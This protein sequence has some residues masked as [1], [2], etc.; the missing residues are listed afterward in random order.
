MQ[1]LSASCFQIL[2]KPSVHHS[3]DPC[4]YRCAPFKISSLIALEE[5]VFTFSFCFLTPCP[6]RIL[7]FS[8]MQLFEN[9]CKSSWEQHLAANVQHFKWYGV[10]ARAGEA[11]R[12]VFLLLCAAKSAPLRQWGW[13]P[14]VQQSKLNL[15]M[16]LC[17]KYLSPA[18]YYLSPDGV[19]AL[20]LQKSNQ[21][22]LMGCER[23]SLFLPQHMGTQSTYKKFTERQKELLDNSFFH[24]GLGKALPQSKLM[25]CFCHQEIFPVEQKQHYCPPHLPLQPAKHI[26]P[27][28]SL[29]EAGCSSPDSV[30]NVTQGR[31]FH[32]PTT[33]SANLSHLYPRDGL[34]LDKPCLIRRAASSK[35]RRDFI[36]WREFMGLTVLP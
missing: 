8:P 29:L 9:V 21:P 13:R 28:S 14:S 11:N 24:A 2:L 3:W 23:P 36:F 22:L 6:S 5:K 17:S 18:G 31:T 16:C 34:G 15:Q 10:Q 35:P 33:A 32:D 27:N 1:V 30:E 25:F 20:S 7:R 26:S 12:Q 4:H 19:W